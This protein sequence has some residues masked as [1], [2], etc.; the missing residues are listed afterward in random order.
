[1]RRSVTIEDDLYSK[2]QQI[3]ARQLMGTG[4]DYPFS[5]CLN[6]YLRMGLDLDKEG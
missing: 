5:K 4:K 2:I 3:R 1:M 6:D